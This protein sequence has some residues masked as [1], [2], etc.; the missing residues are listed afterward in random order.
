[1]NRQ[2]IKIS[3]SIFDKENSEKEIS[4]EEADDLLDSLLIFIELQGYQV[5][6][7]TDNQETT[8]EEML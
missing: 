6:G 2:F 8:P 4:Q 3:L 1:M 5:I 7:Y